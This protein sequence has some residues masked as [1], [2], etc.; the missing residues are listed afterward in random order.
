MRDRTSSRTVNLVNL[1]QINL[2]LVF[3]RDQLVLSQNDSA[4][5]YFQIQFLLLRTNE[6]VTNFQNR[7][8]YLKSS[9]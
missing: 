4:N 5:I 6:E 3:I 1:E 7:A 2:V 9:R 8:G